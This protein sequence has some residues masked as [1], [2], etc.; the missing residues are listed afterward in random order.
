[1]DEAAG[2][3]PRDGVQT[4]QLTTSDGPSPWL[5]DSL[6]RVIVPFGLSRL[7]V[8][9]G[10]LVV[11]LT[12]VSDESPDGYRRL[13]L[14][15][16]SLRGGVSLREIVGVADADWYLGI[17]EAGYEEV[18]FE[19]STPHN[20]AFFPLY[21]LAVRAVSVLTG[22]VAVAAIVL[23]NGLFLFALVLFDRV[24]RESGLDASEV[25]RAIFCICF[26]PVSY[27]FSLPFT[28]SAFLCLSLAAVLLTIRGR[29]WSGA[30]V[31]ALAAATRINGVLLAPVLVL[32]NVRRQGFKASRDIA[33]I[34][35]VSGGLL[36]YAAYL[37]GITG[38]ALAFRDVQTAF[39][40]SSPSWFIAAPFL[41][42]ARRPAL[43]A[44]W[45]LVPLDLASAILGL[46]C[47]FLLARRRQWAFA[48]YVFATVALPLSTGSF[49][50]M[51]RY[52]MS[53][54]PIYFVL[55]QAG[56]RPAADQLLRALMPALLALLSLAC[57]ARYTFAVA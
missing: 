27:F 5:A 42:L 40:R 10:F 30:A 18:P 16:D 21:P 49:T 13:V 39:G 34:S 51:T 54:F 44:G 19:N 4:A 29:H 7:V 33:V 46:S 32:L 36:I 22:S 57:A 56:N 15:Q 41:D 1:V 2:S 35:I 3:K 28:E 25:G 43:F 23:S 17:A 55:A 26:F 31:A 50:A 24:A 6:R 38:N 37:Y 14:R 20:W 9:V 47:A 8:L 11:A 53:A 48:F 12:Q 52:V 45:S